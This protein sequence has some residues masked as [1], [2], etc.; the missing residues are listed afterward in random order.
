[1]DS[2]P[3]RDTF[4]FPTFGPSAMER[5]RHERVVISR[6]CKIF[7]PLTRRYTAALTRDLSEG[8]AMIEIESARPL[9]VGEQIGV[10]VS[11]TDSP[12]LREESLIE[13]VVVRV[14]ETDDDR[15]YVAVRF[16]DACALVAAA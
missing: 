2:V 6:A 3:Q 5:R 10:G 11:W 1:M 13:G 14:V 15:Q 16:S 4:P 9:A 7:R 8:G 12:V